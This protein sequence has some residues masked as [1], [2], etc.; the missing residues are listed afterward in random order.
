VLCCA[1][2]SPTSLANGGGGFALQHLL[3]ITADEQSADPVGERRMKQMTALIIA[4]DNKTG[5]TARRYFMHK[6][7]D[8][9]NILSGDIFT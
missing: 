6:I 7:S 1:A 2:K 3:V 5:V 8:C 9:A 4:D